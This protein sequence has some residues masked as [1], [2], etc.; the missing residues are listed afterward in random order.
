MFSLRDLP[1]MSQLFSFWQAHSNCRMTFWYHMYG[2][3]VGSL[4][5]Y[6]NISNRLTLWWRKSGSKGNQW[7]QAVVGIGKKIAPFQILIQGQEMIFARNT[8]PFTL[9]ICNCEV[10]F[11]SV[12][13]V[14]GKQYYRSYSKLSFFCDK[15]LYHILL[16]CSALLYVALLAIVL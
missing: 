5:V 13:V 6:L 2:Y 12:L 10:K 16:L 7:R 1:V 4:N 9:L 15:L 11:E 8:S 14:L 3:S